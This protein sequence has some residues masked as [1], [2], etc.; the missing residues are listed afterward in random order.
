MKNRRQFLQT[1][2]MGLAF[3]AYWPLKNDF[4]SN[5]DS[6]RSGK[7]IL[8][9]GDSITDAHR[10]KSAYYPNQAR[11]LGSGYVF[12]ASARLLEKH[13]D[14]ELMIYNRGISGHKVFQLANRWEDDCLN[15]KPDVLS[16]L[17]GV[18]DYWHK[19]NGHYN[20]TVKIYEDD[21]RAL[22]NRTMEALPDLKL[23]ICEPFAVRGGRAI[24]ESDWF[25]KFDEYRQVAKSLA[26]EFKATFIPF[27]SIFNEALNRGDVDYWCPDG[28]HPSIAGAQLMADHWVD[29]VKL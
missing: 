21:Y 23:V 26:E 2:S 5:F 15:L 27:Q 20:G 24:N 28:V 16:I 13:P 1:A 12:A 19:I 8:F 9:Q 22:L 3:S 17:I 4:L 29:A 7:I 18:N 25:P 14:Q 10:D 11:G 6:N